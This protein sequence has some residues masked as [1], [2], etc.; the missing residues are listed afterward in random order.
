MP[1]AEKFVALDSDS[2]LG[3]STRE[4]RVNEIRDAFKRY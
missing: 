4:A 1:V 3:A 2:T